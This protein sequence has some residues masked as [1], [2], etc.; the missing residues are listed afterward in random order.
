MIKSQKFLFYVIPVEIRRRGYFQLVP[1]SHFRESDGIK[2]FLRSRQ[3]W[4][5]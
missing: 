2:G 3:T 1:D 4:E 5:K